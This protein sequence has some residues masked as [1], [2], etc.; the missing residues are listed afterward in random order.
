[1]NSF[2]NGNG[3]G[4]GYCGSKMSWNAINAY[5]ND[6]KPISKWTKNEILS[7]IEDE[8]PDLYETAKKVCAKDLKYYFL[9][10]TS[11]HHTGNHYQKTDFYSFNY[12]NNYD[13][14]FLEG[15]IEDH[16]KAVAIAKGKEPEINKYRGN[17]TYLEWYGTRNHPHADEINLENVNI[18]ERG[19]F[20]YVTDDNNKLLIRKKIGSN[21][22]Y[23]ISNEELER[24]AKT[25]YIENYMPV[26]KELNQAWGYNCQRSFSGHIYAHGRKAPHNAYNCDGTTDFY[27]IGERRIATKKTVEGFD[28]ITT[29]SAEEWDGIKWIAI[30]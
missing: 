29:Y 26:A 11:W 4:N 28:I 5:A 25:R 30:E 9:N 8:Y 24:R 6:E 17:F 14:E 1:M 2:N 3:R 7:I 22:T 19:C 15:V 13:N 20:Y 12:R 21:G 16:K 10:K 18:E 27:N 23:A